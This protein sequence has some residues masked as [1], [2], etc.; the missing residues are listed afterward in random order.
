MLKDV[1]TIPSDCVA[2][3]FI[4]AADTEEDFLKKRLIKGDNKI[5]NKKTAI[6]AQPIAR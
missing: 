3:L 1:E 6:T 2:A 4:N 5:L